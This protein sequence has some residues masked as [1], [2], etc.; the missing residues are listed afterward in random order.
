MQ[1]VPNT[2]TIIWFNGSKNDQNQMH[3]SGSTLVCLMY[4]VHSPRYM[5]GS[6]QRANLGDECAIRPEVK[7]SN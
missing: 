2:L 1:S 5:E 6:E 7:W 4:V 3:S